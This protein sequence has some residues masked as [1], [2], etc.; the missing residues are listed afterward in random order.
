MA[1]IR[2]RTYANTILIVDEAQNLSPLEVKTIVTRMGE[3]SKVIFTGDIYQID[4]KYLD[5]NNN[6][7]T[8]LIEKA[9]FYVH[10]AHINLVKGERSSLAEW[11]GKNL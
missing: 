9:K 8:Y 5:S 6:G 2:G 3:N 1:Y 11:G 4:D 7:L 10:A